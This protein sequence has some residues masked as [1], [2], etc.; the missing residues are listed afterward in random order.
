MLKLPSLKNKPKKTYI[1]LGLHLFFVLGILVS[2]ALPRGVTVWMNDVAGSVTNNIVNRIK[3]VKPVRPERLEIGDHTHNFYSHMLEGDHFKIAKGDTFNIEIKQIFPEGTKEELKDKTI[4]VNSSDNNNF[5]DFTFFYEEAKSNLNIYAKEIKDNCYITLSI[6]KTDYSLKIEFDIIDLI[7]PKKENIYLS[8]LNPK[9]GSS[10]YISSLY[11]EPYQNEIV[12]DG[13]LITHLEDSVY[14]GLYYNNPSRNVLYYSP[15]SETHIRKYLDLSTHQYISDDPNIYIDPIN[16][17]VKINEGT[18]IGEHQIT[19]NFGGKISFNISN[20]VASPIVDD[21]AISSSKDYVSPNQLLSAY[22]GQTLTLSGESLNEHALVVK[23]KDTSICLANIKKSLHEANFTFKNQLFLRGDNKGDT[24]LEVY[25][26]EDPSI[27]LNDYHI[28]CDDV[29]NHLNI[30][31]ELYFDDVLF[32]D[33]KLDKNKEYDLKILIRNKTTNELETLS[34]IDISNLSNYYSFTE[35]E[36]AH[37]KITFIGSGDIRMNFSF[38]Y[39]GTYCPNNYE[40]QVVDNSKSAV[41]NIDPK[42]IRKSVGH[43]LLHLL[44]SLFLILFLYNYIPDLDKKK[45]LYIILFVFISSL[46]LAFL[47]EFIQLFIPGRCFDML[48]ILIDISACIVFQLTLLIV[49]LVKYRKKPQ[50]IE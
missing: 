43:S 15:S 2:A 12:E 42:T 49:V 50:E 38:R 46:F 24:N 8:N 33:Q 31:V 37:Y 32:T 39:N 16:E 4:V 44:S 26:Y 30:D 36:D 20:E 34:T 19:S 29:L 21:L 40:L 7:V 13:Y 10:F 23:S 25:Y 17:I 35:I 45:K 11:L 27:K 47:S 48:D 1:F 18:R 9:I 6:P 3:G 14:G 41:S 22:I 28:K 5:K